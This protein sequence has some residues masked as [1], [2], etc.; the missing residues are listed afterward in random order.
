[1]QKVPSSYKDPSGSVFYDVGSNCFYR[2]LRHPPSLYNTIGAFPQVLDNKVGDLYEVETI[3]FINYYYEWTF[4]QFKDSAIYFLELLKDLDTQGYTF[5]DATPLNVTYSGNGKFTFIDHGS[6]IKKESEMWPAFYQFLKEYA[7]P[8]LYL[9]ENPTLPPL[10]LLP[11]IASKDWMFTYKPKLSHRVSL[12]YALLKSALTLSSKKSLTDFSDKKKKGLS[13]QYRYNIEF[14][15]D[16]IKGLNHKLPTTT[17][18]GNYYTETVLGDDYV[19]NKKKA[20]L[21]F[22]QLIAPEV[23]I[24]MDLGASDG[25]MSEHIV[26]HFPDIKFISVESDPLAS[27]DLYQRSKKSNILPIY[28]S[29]YSLTPA[30]GFSESIESLSKRVSKSVDLVMGLGI[31]HHLMH[32]E[33]LSFDRILHFMI[34]LIK[35]KGHL[36]IEYISFNDPRHQL[37]KNINYPHSTNI[38]EWELAIAKVGEIVTKKALD[39]NR[40]MYLIKPI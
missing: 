34:G 21:E 35:T 18:W 27:K 31:I 14:F 17:R 40:S 19:Q 9:S 36:I 3:P 26:D 33:N 11:L 15:L 28:N 37:I 20:L 29:L 10:S 2:S 12:N 6:L 30:L 23:K 39:L 5:S 8:L 4:E 1:M 7:Y 16:Y 24:G 32:E 38:E 22:F 13:N 25:M